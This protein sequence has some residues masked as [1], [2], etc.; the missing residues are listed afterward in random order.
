[1]ALGYASDLVAGISDDNLSG[2]PAS[3]GDNVVYTP[4][5]GRPWRLNWLIIQNQ[6]AT[7]QTVQIQI[8]PSGGPYVAVGPHWVLGS[9]QFMALQWGRG[10]DVKSSDSLNINLLN[11]TAVSIYGGIKEGLKQ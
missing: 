6:V 2:E 3:A 5:T 4:P 8:G 1:M 11:P 9:K 7:D 10:K